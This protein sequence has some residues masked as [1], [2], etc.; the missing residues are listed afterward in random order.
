MQVADCVLEDLS[1]ILRKIYGRVYV[2]ERVCFFR[3]NVGLYDGSE[4]VIFFSRRYILDKF[5]IDLMNS[6]KNV[7]DLNLLMLIKQERKTRVK[8]FGVV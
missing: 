4:F 2:I 7:E 1:G 5:G 8:L 6:V 3:G